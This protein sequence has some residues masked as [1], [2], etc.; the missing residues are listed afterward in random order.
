MKTRFCGCLHRLHNNRP[1]RLDRRVRFPV[2]IRHRA[3]KA[4]IYAP[5]GSSLTPRRLR[6]G[7]QTPDAEPSPPI[8]TPKPPRTHC[9]RTGERITGRRALGQPVPRRPCRL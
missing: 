4:K 8:P 6:H 2:T 1:E 3:S 7:W 9:A 5:A